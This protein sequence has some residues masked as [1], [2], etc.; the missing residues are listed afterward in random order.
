MWLFAP[1]GSFLILPVLIEAAPLIRST[2]LRLTAMLAGALA[3]VGWAAAAAAPAYSADRQQRFVIQH[4]TDLKAFKSSW[5]VLND[6]A[7]L[8][9]GAGSGWTRGKL[10]FSNRPRWLAPAPTDAKIPAAPGVQR[11]GEVRKNN[12]RTLTL[13]FLSAG[14]DRIELVAPA[15]AKILAAGAAGYVRPIDATVQEGKYYIDCF[16]RS[17]DG[18]TFQLVIG[19]LKPVDV[20]VLGYHGGLPPS[21]GSLLSARPKFARPQYNRDETIAFARTGL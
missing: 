20:L 21:A 18:L 9:A 3:L 1:L 15:N 14:F 8:P 19:Q 5:S 2:G 16:G 7:S 4:V 17:C 12:S 6:A 13:R 11:L 10:P